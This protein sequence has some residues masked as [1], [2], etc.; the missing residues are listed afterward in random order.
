MLFIG[1]YASLAAGLLVGN[2]GDGGLYVVQCIAQSEIYILPEVGGIYGRYKARSWLHYCN[3]V[4]RFLS[5]VAR[6]S[7]FFS[8]FSISNCSWISAI[9]AIF[10]AFSSYIFHYPYSHLH[11]EHSFF[12]IFIVI[13]FSFV[14]HTPLLFFSFFV[15]P[16]LTNH[17]LASPSHLYPGQK[18]TILKT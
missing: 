10:Y 9:P 16:Y 2:P 13:S 8:Y 4:S 3:G 1:N 11:V 17:L 7:F 14:S 5:L 12:F 15:L 18:K 6:F